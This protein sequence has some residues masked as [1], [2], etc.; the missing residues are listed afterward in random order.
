[1]HLRRTRET[2]AALSLGLALLAARATRTASPAATLVHGA[3]ELREIAYDVGVQMGRAHPKRPDGG[4][5]KERRKEVARSLT[6]IEARVRAAIREMAARTEEAWRV[7]RANAR[8][9]NAR[10][11]PGT[12]E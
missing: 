9:A 2:A 1:M 11:S 4:V 7:F 6:S 12:L 5:D 8:R 10:H 3:R